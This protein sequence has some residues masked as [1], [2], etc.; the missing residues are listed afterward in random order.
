M[1]THNIT[2]ESFAAREKA[3]LVIKDGELR[4]TSK[5]SLKKQPHAIVSASI[6]EKFALPLR[7]DITVKIEKQDLSKFNLLVGKGHLSFLGGGIA[8]RTD[9]YTGDNK[10]SM[11]IFDNDIPENEYADISVTYG[12][13]MMWVTVNSE[14]RYSCDSAPY[15]ALIKK[16]SVPDEFADGITIAFACDKRLIMNVKSMVVAEYEND[17]PTVPQEIASLPEISP[18]EIRVKNCAPDLSDEIKNEIIKIDK[19]LLKDMKKSLKFKRAFELYDKISY[20]SPHGFR[21]KVNFGDCNHTIAWISYNSKREQKKHSGYKK[22]DYTVETLNKLAQ[23]SPEFAARV[24]SQIKV[25]RNCSSRC[26]N[27]WIY[28]FGGETIT[29]CG[30]GGGMIFKFTSSDFDD[31]RKVIIATDDVLAH[32]SKPYAALGE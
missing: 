5:A 24:F 10:P 4:I 11:Y 14:C 29:G 9:I 21:Y 25:C 27:K 19:F 28:E 31:V 16:N 23:S 18:L 20:V 8:T 22:A 13:Q 32:V 12:R 2:L 26:S 6:D 15:M 3:S 17:E 1:I 7:I 30:W